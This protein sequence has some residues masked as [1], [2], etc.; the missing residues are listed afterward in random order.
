MVHAI[1]PFPPDSVMPV[2][3]KMHFTNHGR[4]TLVTCLLRKSVREDIET[5][6]AYCWL[7]ASVINF[8]Y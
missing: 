7:D 2:P 3:A 4:S 5:V 1:F 6:K 8:R